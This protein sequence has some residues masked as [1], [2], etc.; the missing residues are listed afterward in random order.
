MDVE[1]VVAVQ[2]VGGEPRWISAE[3]AGLFSVAC[4]ALEVVG[5]C[6]R[7]TDPA[8]ATAPSPDDGSP[9]P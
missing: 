6:A 8:T 3:D 2:R 4:E 1:G 5:R 9:A 7:M